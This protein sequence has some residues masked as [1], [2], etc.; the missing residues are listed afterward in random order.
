MSMFDTIYAELDCPFCG[1]Q[2]RYSP[3]NWE[4]A[5][6]ETKDHKQ[7]QLEY[8]GEEQKGERPMLS[9]LQPAWARRDGFD[10]V[11]VWIKQ[12]DMP[13]N[14]EAYRTRKHLGLAEIQTKAFECV[15][16][17]YFISDEVPAY[18]GHY[19]IPEAFHCIGCSNEDDYVF[20]KV[21]IEIENLRVKAVHTYNPETGDPEKASFSQQHRRE[22]DQQGSKSLVEET[23][24]APKL[25]AEFPSPDGR[26][27]LKNLGQTM[28]E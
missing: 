27:T 4:E 10:D 19:F 26:L 16:R 8:R 17:E 28:H 13:E 24:S 6:Q 14:I 25:S 11:D 23:G 5:E 21:W 15:M 3:M 9:I 18:P 22:A 12:L 1:K 2:Y 20:V 7:S